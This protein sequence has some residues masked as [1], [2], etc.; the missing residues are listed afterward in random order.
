MESWGRGIE[1]FLNECKSHGL[2]MPLFDTSMSG[3]MLTFLASTVSATTQVTTPE[4]TPEIVPD[5]TRV[6]VLRLLRQQ[7]TL[8]RRQI[9]L[10]LGLSADG[11]KYHLKEL[12]EEGLIQHVGPTKAGRWLILK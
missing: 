12:Q 3:L 10:H 6:K 9:S 5:A 11:I 7:P 1:K 4:I 2:P 8:T